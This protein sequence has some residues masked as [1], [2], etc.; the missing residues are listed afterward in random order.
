MGF[1]S[2]VIYFFFAEKMAAPE[3]L[4][5][6]QQYMF[7]SSSSPTPAA[8]LAHMSRRRF[9][10]F[11]TVTLLTAFITCFTLLSVTLLKNEEL[12]NKLLNLGQTAN[13]LLNASSN[14]QSWALKQQSPANWNDILNFIL[15]LS[16]TC[17][18]EAAEKPP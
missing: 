7:N 9:F 2:F 16:H 10:C 17:V 15:Q 18:Q 12:Q 13:C 1:S 5:N 8:D 6:L 11:Q 3:P 4:R 14:D